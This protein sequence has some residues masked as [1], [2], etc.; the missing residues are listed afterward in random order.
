MCCCL[1]CENL[2]YVVKAARNGPLRARPSALPP[3]GSTPRSAAH[4]SVG[5][6]HKESRTV[7]THDAA[8]ATTD[9]AAAKRLTITGTLGSRNG[10]TNTLMLASL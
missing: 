3:D 5:Y 2:L 8:M 9:A 6:E 4:R 1:S 10:T 7:N